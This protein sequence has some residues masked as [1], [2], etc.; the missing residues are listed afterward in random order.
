MDITNIIIAFI[1]ILLTVITSVFIPWL[2]AKLTTN[3]INII[4]QL[5][6]IA[7]YAAQQTCCTNEEKKEYALSYVKNELAKYHI[8]FSDETV[9]TYIEGI[10]KNIKLDEG[11]NW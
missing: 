6:S 3:Q 4:R 11:N 9:S 10:L 2:K 5:A 1:G 8:T 7:V